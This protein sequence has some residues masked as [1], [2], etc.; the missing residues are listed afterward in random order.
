MRSHSDIIEGE[1]LMNN[2]F[3]QE[4]FPKID[5]LITEIS[6]CRVKLLEVQRQLFELKI[7]LSE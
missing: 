7:T 2:D 6:E 1:T 4:T 5:D 3:K